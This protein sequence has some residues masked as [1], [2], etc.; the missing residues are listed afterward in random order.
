MSG[1]PPPYSAKP[2]PP[3]YATAVPVAK[4][5]PQQ[6]PPYA[7]AAPVAQQQQTGQVVGLVNPAH[8]NLT[9]G[10]RVRHMQEQLDLPEDIVRD[11][12]SVAGV[13]IVVIADDS[14]S[15][16]QVADHANTSNPKTRWEELQETLVKLAHLLLVVDHSD[17]FHVQ[18]LNDPT[19]HEIHSK[20]H[21]ETLFYGRQAR[22]RTPLGA[23]LQP[24][25]DGSWHPKGHRVE[26]ELIVLAMT[27]G[28]PSDVSFDG[29]R[30]LVASKKPS[31]FVTFL[32]CTEDDDDV[33]AYNKYVD[34][35]PGVD[36]TDDYV[37]E[38]RE[39]EAHGKRLSYYKWMAKAVLGGKMP[40]YDQLDEKK[41]GAGGCCT[42]S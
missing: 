17:G 19:W 11:L 31:V 25:L 39:V 37:S 24:V 3:P 40:K 6:T 8:V 23:R 35:I 36:I 7:Q 16:N 9:L 10:D 29:L 4:P 26:T 28:E 13:D 2:P 12:L 32:M 38:Q 15:M 22:G 33:E 30:Q 20:E 21:V 34:H 14:G 1:P 18:F 42:V 41:A 5:Q 27:D